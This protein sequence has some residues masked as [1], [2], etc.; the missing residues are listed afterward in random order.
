M[1]KRVIEQLLEWL[2]TVDDETLLKVR[3]TLE[4]DDDDS[5]ASIASYEHDVIAVH[6]AN[7]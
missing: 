7:D 1:H 2:K 4:F 5:N 3:S 6:V